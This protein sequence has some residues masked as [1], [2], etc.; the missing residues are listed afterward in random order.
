MNWIPLTQE[1]QLQEIVGLSHLQPVV[2][3][4]HSTRCSISGTA[5]SRLERHWKDSEMAGVKPYHLDLIAHRPV[6]NRIAQVFGV[7]HQSPQLLLIREGEC[8]FNASHLDISYNDLK[9]RLAEVSK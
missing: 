1:A 5:L 6:S 2:I 4:K 8:V 7:E 3:F 9:Q